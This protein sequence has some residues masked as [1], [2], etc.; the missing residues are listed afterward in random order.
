M[1]TY[2][3][4][5]HMTGMLKSF[6]NPDGDSWN[7]GVYFLH[8]KFDYRPKKTEAEIRKELMDMYNERIKVN[9]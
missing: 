4:R 8:E 9:E 2:T 7:S 3:Y 6:F 1:E 5:V